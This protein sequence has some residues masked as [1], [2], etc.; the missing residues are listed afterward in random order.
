M[1]PL[2]PPQAPPT[3]K[4]TVQDVVHL[5]TEALTKQKKVIDGIVGLAE[6]RLGFENVS[7][8]FRTPYYRR[9][10]SLPQVF[11]SLH[12]FNRDRLR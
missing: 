11:V 4:H 2:T 9:T 8:I 12:K 3:W 7:A 6:D 10:H 1:V 5:I